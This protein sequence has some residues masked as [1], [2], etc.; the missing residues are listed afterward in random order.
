M[1]KE[2]IKKYSLLEGLNVS[3]ETYLDFEKYISMI[4]EKNKEIN[5][6]SNKTAENSIIRD[7]HIIDSAQIVDFIDLNSSIITDIGSGSGMPGIV[8]AII[9]KNKKKDIKFYLYEKSYHKTMFLKKVSKDLNLDVEVIQRDIFEI[10]KLK[11]DTIMARAFKPLPVILDL[12]IRNF[13][14]YKNLILFMGKSG[15]SILQNT[16]KEWDFEYQKKN[17]ITSKDSF[18]LNIRNIKK[19]FLN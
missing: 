8:A 16:L 9:M 7:R 5:I 1:E 17:S 11:S 19:K 15:Q 4:I 6:I 18:L 12:V 13:S 2:I 14:S 10:K 3:R